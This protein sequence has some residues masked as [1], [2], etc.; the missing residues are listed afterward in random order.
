MGYDSSILTLHS[1]RP[2]LECILQFFMG[3]VMVSLSKKTKKLVKEGRVALN[4]TI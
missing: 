3:L 1:S 4:F 2:L